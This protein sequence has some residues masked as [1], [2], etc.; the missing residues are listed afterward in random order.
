MCLFLIFD[1]KLPTILL[2]QGKQIPERNPTP[3]LLA[4]GK[5]QAGF[6][7]NRRIGKAS[8]N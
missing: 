5:Y 2:D 4:K 6:H 1:G 7:S 3:L 8:Q